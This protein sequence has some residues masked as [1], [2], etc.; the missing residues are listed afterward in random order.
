MHAPRVAVPSAS[1]TPGVPVQPAAP[2]GSLKR[3]ASRPVVAGVRKGR[4]EELLATAF[5]SST[6]IARTAVAAG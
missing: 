2:R 3:P 4:H 1:S 6:G 5:S